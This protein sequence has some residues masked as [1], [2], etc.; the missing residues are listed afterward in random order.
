MRTL[1]QLLDFVTQALEQGQIPYMVSGSLALNEYAIP[2]MTMDID[3][4]IDI[5]EED[6]TAL[7][8]IFSE[9]FFFDDVA[10]A[11]EIKQRGMFN[12]LDTTSGFKIDFMVR[13]DT[14]YRRTEF[15]RRKFVQSSGF[16]AWMVSP[17]DLII[18]KL[19]W[20][21]VL[22]SDRQHAD[23]SKLLTRSDLDRGYIRYWIAELGLN[24]FDLPV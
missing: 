5:Q 23:I 13:K 8:G 21:Q 19:D 17:E 6:I 14:L 16:A 2:R 20:I 22:Q 24:T 7:R 10:A 15:E 18:S 1:L 3:I 9:D 12:V 4:V 11:T